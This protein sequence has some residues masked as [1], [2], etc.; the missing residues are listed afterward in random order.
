MKYKGKGRKC[1]SNSKKRRL[2]KQIKVRKAVWKFLVDHA[3]VR[4]DG[5]MFVSFLCDGESNFWA[6]VKAREAGYRS[7][8]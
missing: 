7:K 2:H 8:E 5:K 1:D 4:D 6:R 3:K